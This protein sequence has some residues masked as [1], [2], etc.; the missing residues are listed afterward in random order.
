MI[1]ILGSGAHADDISTLCGRIGV[2]CSMFDHHEQAPTDVR[3]YVIG[4]NDPRTRAEARERF[5]KHEWAAWPLIDPTVVSE[6]GNYARGVVIAA[7]SVLLS[8]DLGVH[9]HV[10]VH[11]TVI[12]AQIGAFTT[13]APGVTI[14]G[15]VTIGAR[16]MIGAGAVIKNL[17][18]IGDD[19]TVG[20]GAVVVN[21]IPDGATVKGVPAR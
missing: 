2:E 3:D 6:Y 10:N 8:V 1:S 9:A 21:D 15:D 7:G 4:I 12:R 18:S 16:C 14:C 17:V 11:A 5:G 13:I 20:A 19:V